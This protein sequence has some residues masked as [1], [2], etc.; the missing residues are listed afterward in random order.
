[1]GQ[2]KEAAKVVEEE[3]EQEVEAQKKAG[4]DFRIGRVSL[5]NNRLQFDN[6]NKP[7]ARYGMDYSHLLGDSLTLHIENFVLN[8]D[9][10]GGKITRG[11]QN[12]ILKNS[13]ADHGQ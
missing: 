11:A 8:T 12:H 5:N 4:W 7:Q 9:S 13:R 3:I 1:M 6:D 2:R 10:I